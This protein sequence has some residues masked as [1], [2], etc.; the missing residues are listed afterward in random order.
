MTLRCGLCGLLLLLAL[1]VD[2]GAAELTRDAV[3]AQLE[4]ARAAGHPADLSGR[5][6]AGLDLHLR[7]RCQPA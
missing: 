6:L 5:S 4:K 3:A 7:R 2:A 1:P